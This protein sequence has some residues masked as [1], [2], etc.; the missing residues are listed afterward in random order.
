ML[1]YILS[2]IQNRAPASDSLLKSIESEPLE[3]F[4]CFYYDDAGNLTGNI[5]STLF[6]NMLYEN[7]FI[8]YQKI[9][10]YGEEILLDF[11][12]SEDAENEEI[13]L[14]IY[15]FILK[16]FPLLEM[17]DHITPESF[18]FLSDL[19]GD[20]HFKISIHIMQ[21]KFLYSIILSEKKEHTELGQRII[22]SA[23]STMPYITHSSI[24]FNTE[25]QNIIMDANTQ[26]LICLAFSFFEVYYDDGYYH[27]LTQSLNHHYVYSALLKLYHLIP[28]IQ[29]Y[30][31]TILSRKERK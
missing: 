1:A 23:I 28:Q 19:L 27:Y 24:Y 20:E 12:V 11:P 2:E 7:P 30:S 9:T 17:F 16:K 3:D 31:D 8:S 26:T 29:L 4:S 22:S 18:Y 6:S 21:S 25:Y 10:F 15:Q 5:L 13:Y 14:F